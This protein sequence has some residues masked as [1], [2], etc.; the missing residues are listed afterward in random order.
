MNEPSN[1]V[2]GAVFPG[3]SDAGRIL[4]Q[5]PYMPRKDHGIATLDAQWMGGDKLSILWLP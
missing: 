2:N 1:F 4:N 3:C 5:P